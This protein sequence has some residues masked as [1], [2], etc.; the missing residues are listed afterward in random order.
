MRE[1][2]HGAYRMACI[3]ACRVAYRVACRV[4]R[5]AS[6]GAVFFGLACGGAE[7]K[8]PAVVASVSTVDTAVADLSKLRANIPSAVADTF[9]PGGAARR[10][11]ANVPD[12]PPALMDAVER[13][14]GTSR[15]CYQEYGQK[16]DGK[17][18]GAVALVV[19][20]EGNAVRGAR[21]GSDDWSS[22]AGRGV[23]SCLVQ[24]APQAWKILPGARIADGRYVVQLR[25]R[26]L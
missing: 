23:N 6:V 21:V 13:E 3:M 10:G 17:L 22:G 19:T 24:K 20:V 11:I 1:A 12:A 25:F 18:V 2:S 16:V 14:E 7:P 15:F 26:P 9:T 8:A 4:P 5:T